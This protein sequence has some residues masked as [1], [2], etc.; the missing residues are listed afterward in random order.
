MNRKPEHRHSTYKKRTPQ[1][2]FTLILLRLR[3][4][5]R[6]LGFVRDLTIWEWTKIENNTPV[7]GGHAY[8]RQSIP[9]F[10][11]KF[12]LKIK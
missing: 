11:T 5:K 3:V 7:I 9:K 12:V 8:C 6:R 4:R 2:G 10:R 1:I